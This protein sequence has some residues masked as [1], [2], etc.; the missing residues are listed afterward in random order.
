MT[1]KPIQLRPVLFAFLFV[2]PIA[3]MAQKKKKVKP[4]AIIQTPY[5]EIHLKLYEDTPL[6]RNNF[7]KLAKEGAYDGTTFHRVMKEFMVQGG[8][9]YSKDPEKKHLAGTGGP[10]Y[11]LPKEIRPQ[12]IHKKGALAAARQPDNVNPEW[13]SSGSQFYIVHGRTFS[14]REI[15]NTERRIGMAIGKE[16]HYSEADKE[17]YMKEGGAPW[18]DQQYTIYGEVIKGFDVID[19]IAEV[20]VGRGNRPK[21]DV[22]MTVIAK[23]KPAK[24]KKKK[25]KKKK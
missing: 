15:L 21:S 23:A 7:L 5:G 11:T 2:L 8:D 9:P 20:E 3:L 6:H 12:Y 18:L 24:V 22:A 13:N 17:A 10:G 1:F 16:F 19:K 25:K 14:E 4:D